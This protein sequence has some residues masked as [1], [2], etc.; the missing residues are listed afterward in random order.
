[1]STSKGIYF[2]ARNIVKPGAYAVVNASAMVPNRLGA[3]NTIAVIGQAT[4]GKPQT[5]VKINSPVL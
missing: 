5:F 1:M 2:G 4:G 3:A